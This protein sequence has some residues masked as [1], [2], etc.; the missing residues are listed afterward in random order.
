MVFVTLSLPYF[1]WKVWSNQLAI[2]WKQNM[3]TLVPS[4][5]DYVTLPKPKKE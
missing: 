2:K 5:S 4:F 3:K 1:P